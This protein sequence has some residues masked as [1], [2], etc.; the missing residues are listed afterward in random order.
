MGPFG[1]RGVIRQLPRNND[2]KGEED[3]SGEEEKDPGS[4]LYFCHRG[5]DVLY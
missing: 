2:G 3:Y 1:V 5:S 4:F